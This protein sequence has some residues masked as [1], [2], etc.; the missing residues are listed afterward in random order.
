MGKEG[1]NKSGVGEGWRHLWHQCCVLRGGGVGA[2]KQVKRA[3]KCVR[4]DDVFFSIRKFSHY[5]KVLRC[6]V[7]HLGSLVLRHLLNQFAGTANS[8]S[9]QIFRPPSTLTIYI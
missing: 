7:N 6:Q 5:S 3:E 9:S 2:E 1:S 8:P 4:A